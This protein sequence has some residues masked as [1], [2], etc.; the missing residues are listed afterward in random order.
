TNSGVNAKGHAEIIKW[1]HGRIICRPAI[2]NDSYFGL[3]FRW[4]AALPIATNES[5]YPLSTRS[6]DTGNISVGAR[7][8]ITDPQPSNCKR[9]D[10]RGSSGIMGRAVRSDV[11]SRWW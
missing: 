11:F 7:L 5:N 10:I 2:K 1:N 3:A 9:Y 8:R 4:R 6:G